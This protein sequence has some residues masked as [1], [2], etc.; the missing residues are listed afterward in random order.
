MLVLFHA[1]FT[2]NFPFDESE[3]SP[4]FTGE[5]ETQTWRKTK[6]FFSATFF[7][8]IHNDTSCMSQPTVNSGAGGL[9]EDSPSRHKK[10]FTKLSLQVMLYPLRRFARTDKRSRC[11]TFFG[12]LTGSF[13]MRHACSMETKANCVVSPF[14]VFSSRKKCI[15][16][17]SRT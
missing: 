7:P 8:F 14:R 13:C 10:L 15:V 9:V 11:D 6:P 3:F 17:T 16:V 12:W 2:R 5:Y 1:S 4:I